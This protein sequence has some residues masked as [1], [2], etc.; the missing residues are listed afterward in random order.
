LRLRAVREVATT[1]TEE[2]RRSWRPLLAAGLLY[3]LAEVA[4]LT[5]LVSLGIRQ[6]VSLSGT[7][8]LSDK[9]ILAFA[10]RPA[11]IATLVAAASGRIAVLALGQACLMGIAFGAARN[12]R[13]TVLAAF[14]WGA[15]RLGKI[16]SVTTRLVFKV[17]LICAPFLAVAA[18]AYFSLLTEFDI[19][20]YLKERPPELWLAALAI[21]SALLV[22]TALLLLRA[23]GWVYALPLLLFENV[24]PSKVLSASEDRSEGHRA[25]IA[26]VL[27]AWTAATTAT[28]LLGLWVVRAL[29]MALLPRARESLSLLVP[30]LGAVVVLWVVEIA[31]VT[32]FAALTFA[33]LVIALYTSLAAGSRG[34]LVPRESAASRRPFPQGGR[35]LVAV[36]AAA[37]LSVGV[38]W[39]LLAGARH[40]RPVA[41]IGHRGASASAP[42]NTLAAF[43]HGIEEGADWIELDVQ[44]TVDGEVV[45]LHD[46]DF[47][48]LAGSPLKIWEASFEEVR[49]LDI[50]SWFGPRFQGEKIP[51]LEE[52]LLRVKGRA[53]VIIELKY[54]GHDQQLEERV[55][56]IVDRAGMER[57]IA[58]MSLERRGV[59]KMQA[60][61]PG[62]RT[63]LVA[64]TAVGRLSEA[65]ADFLAVSVA[66]ATPSLIRQAHARGREVYVWT[67]ND[68]LSMAQQI[69]RGADGLITDHPARAKAVIRREADLTPVERLLLGAAFWLGVVP[70]KFELSRESD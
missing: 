3:Q 7:A 46:S 9:E 43:E 45:V 28:S 49:E 39:A 18:L 11:G 2:L 47:M 19:N 62:V 50:G 69:L 40:V 48:K 23:A 14:G 58:V 63:G 35:V 53:K 29:A 13:F 51:T 16:L 20:Y 17:L 61:R 59:E 6:L 42:E 60:L 38:G 34:E 1:A 31:V 33:A 64:A 15:A 12:T 67:V 10:L 65:N 54:Y 70:E 32:A 30:S 4:L 8:V 21:G 27:V 41:V 68:E 57:D 25:V 56:G 52:A 37:A 44:E 24:E 55:A 22:M 5:P 36:I 26:M 66:L